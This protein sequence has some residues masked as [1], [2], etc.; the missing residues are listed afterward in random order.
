M[1]FYQRFRRKPKPKVVS[2][3]PKEKTLS[4]LKA[5]L[6]DIFNAYIRKRD[7]LWDKGQPYFICISCNHPKSIDE[8][9]AGHFHPVGGNDVIRYDEHSVNGQCIRCNHFMHSNHAGYIRGMIKK[10]GQKV[11]DELEI[12]RHNRSKM[13]KFEVSLLIQHYEEK[14]KK[15]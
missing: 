3:L 14:L 4:V 7:T 6:Q 9:N 8:M 2:K 12:R 10:W 1:P 5:D 13:M 11:V 15:K